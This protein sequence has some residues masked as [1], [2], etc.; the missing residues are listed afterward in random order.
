MNIGHNIIYLLKCLLISKDSDN[1]LT[2]QFPKILWILY[3]GKLVS[4]GWLKSPC[5]QS[6]D[7]L[8]YRNVAFVLREFFSV[9]GVT[10]SCSGMRGR[11]GEDKHFNLKKTQNFKY[12]GRHFDVLEGIFLRQASNSFI[13]VS[14]SRANDFSSHFL[15]NNK[16]K[17]DKKQW[18]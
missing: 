6:Q 9:L 8:W 15:G 5:R 2:S 7:V 11:R 17:E 4:S 14:R 3:L 18:I 12:Q 1:T 10:L 13:I 16:M